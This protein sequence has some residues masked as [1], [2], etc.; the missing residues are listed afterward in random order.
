[1]ANKLYR[2]FAAK[3]LKAACGV[4]APAEQV[5]FYVYATNALFAF[6]VNHSTLSDLP[7]GS[8]PLKSVQLTETLGTDGALHLAAQLNVFDDA[9]I[10][11]M[12]GLVLV[13]E[14]MDGLVPKNSLV[15]FIDTWDQSIKPVTTTEVIKLAFTNGFVFRLGSVAPL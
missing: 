10:T 11:G 2:S 15:A 13:A 6:N 4:G 3:A 7:S 1:V 9:A 14:W 8:F 12:T 5:Q